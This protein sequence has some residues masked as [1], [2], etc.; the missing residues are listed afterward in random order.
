[1]LKVPSDNSLITNSDCI[2]DSFDNSGIG[3]MHGFIHLSFLELLLSFC[4]EDIMFL[5]DLENYFIIQCS[6]ICS[7]RFLLCF[8]TPLPIFSPVLGFIM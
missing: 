3:D 8:S 6:Y 4:R 5:L 7:N 1:M 2:E